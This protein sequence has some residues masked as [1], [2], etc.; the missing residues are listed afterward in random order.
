MVRTAPY[1]A[2][3]SI[4]ALV[5]RVLA[6]GYMTRFD[7]LQLASALLSDQRIVSDEHRQVSLLFDQ[8]QSGHIKIQG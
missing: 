3:A 7:H 1:K 4:Q 2:N 6:T 8:V 5:D